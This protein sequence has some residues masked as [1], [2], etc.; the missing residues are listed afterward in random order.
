MADTKI[1]LPPDSTGASVDT[2][3]VTTGAGVVKREVVSLGD[4]T[5]GANRA[6][7]TAAG[8]LLVTPD[9]VALPANQSVNAAQLAGTATSVNS[10]TKDAGTLRVVLATD[11]PALTNKLLVTPDSVALPANQSVNLNQVGAAAITEGQKAMAASLPVVVASDQSVIPVSDN[12]GSLTVD[13]PVG[14]PAFVR[15]SD[16]AAAQV[17]QKTMAASLPVVVA[18]DQSSL[19]V[20]GTASPLCVVIAPAANTGGTITL[21]AVAGQFHYITA[22][23]VTRNA[24]AALAGTATLAITTTN[25]PGGGTWFRVGNAMIAGGTQK[26]VAQQFSSPIKSSVVNT[27]TTIVF[28]VPGAAVL[29]TATVWYYAAA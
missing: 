9:S 21:P 11:Q 20:T 2:V 13:A 19:P 22:I 8:K 10:G 16:G 27:N 17:G 6:A 7:V 1:Q 5:T 28:P 15:L 4:P 3:D 29:W 12:A 14:T 18:S 26:D 25:L 24:T 23:E